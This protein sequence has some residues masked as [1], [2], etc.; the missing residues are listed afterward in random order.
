LFSGASIALLSGVRSGFRFFFLG[1]EL[2]AIS[3][4]LSAF[5]FWLIADR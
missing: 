1:I 2:S 4:Q 3:F 5:A